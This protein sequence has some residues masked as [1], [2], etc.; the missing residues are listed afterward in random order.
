MLAQLLVLALVAATAS[1]A[2]SYH[3]PNPSPA[4]CEGFFTLPNRDIAFKF[5]DGF[6]DIVATGD[7][8]LDAKACW[9]YAR[10]TNHYG[11]VLNR[12]G[13][14]PAGTIRCFTKAFHRYPQFKGMT[15]YF[16]EYNYGDGRV[17]T[18]RGIAGRY[19][20]MGYDVE[21]G[22]VEGTYAEQD[23]R[24]KHCDLLTELNG[25]AYCKMLDK[26]TVSTVILGNNCQ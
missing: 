7:E 6:K 9:E 5:D 3:P 25:T 8:K 10:D 18:M 2:P 20:V 21:S 22:K 15:Y 12:N 14:G 17:S 11:A 23:A 26:N 19:D 1:A 13:G 16:R 24:W 4:K